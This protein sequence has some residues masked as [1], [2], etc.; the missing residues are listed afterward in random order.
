M[1]FPGNDTLS[2][3]RGVEEIFVE[4]ERRGDENIFQLFELNF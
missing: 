4:I 1:E 3:F 2:I